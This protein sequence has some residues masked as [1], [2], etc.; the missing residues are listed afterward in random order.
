MNVAV[1]GLI[2]WGLLAVWAYSKEHT[3]MAV[4]FGILAALSGLPLIL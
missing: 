3:G 4:L 1:V 2:G